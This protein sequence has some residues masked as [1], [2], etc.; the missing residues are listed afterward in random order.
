MAVPY[1]LTL[2]SYI[3]RMLGLLG[4]SW[5]I[6]VM[7]FQSMEKVPAYVGL[8]EYF[9]S[10]IIAAYFLIS[11]ACVLLVPW[12]AVRRWVHVAL[13]LGWLTISLAFFFHDLPNTGTIVYLALAWIHAAF[14]L[15]LTRLG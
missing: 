15:R 12:H 2:S 7:A 10:W 14:Y 6:W 4:V 8:V 9:P 5:G 3:E 13:F 1:H 11:G